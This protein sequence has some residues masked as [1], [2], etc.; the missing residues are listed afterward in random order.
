MDSIDGHLNFLQLIG[1][2]KPKQRKALL[3]EVCQGQFKAIC[4]LLYNILVGNIPIADKIK[5]KLHRYRN[6]IRRLINKSVSVLEKKRLLINYHYLL[7]SCVDALD[8]YLL[9]EEDSQFSEEEEGEENTNSDCSAAD[10]EQDV[11]TSE[12]DQA[13]DFT[14]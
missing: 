5:Q 8:N 13:Y 12:N 7:P 11:I 1:T 9:D 14:E 3:S 6:I 10:I 4:T 2:S